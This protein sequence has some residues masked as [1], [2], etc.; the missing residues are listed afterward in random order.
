MPPALLVSLTIFCLVGVAAL[1]LRAASSERRR[2]L[3]RRFGVQSLRM[4]LSQAGARESAERFEAIF[5]GILRWVTQRVPEGS[6]ESTRVQQL[7]RRLMQAGFYNAD[8]IKNFRL[9]RLGLTAGC[10]AIAL[11]VCWL[12]GLD[13]SHTRLYFLV[14]G[15]VGYMA[16]A[17]Y[18]TRRGANRRNRI[19]RE[20][21]DT[22]DL[23]T[24]CVEAGLSMF[25][26]IKTV[27]VESTRRG[28]TIGDELAMVS[29][30]VAIG[31]SLGDAL[32]NL[33]ERTAVEEI[34][35]LAATLI[36]SEQLGAQ[37]APALRASSDALRSRRQLRAEE[38]AQKTA[39][40][41]LLPL[42]LFVLP[43]MIAVIMGPAFIQIYHTIAH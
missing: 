23:L 41:M 40:K 34:R 24:V 4:L 14:G 21:A 42:V 31:S 25:E 11:L 16:P 5:E 12:A 13:G 20:L 26:G 3:E 19:S 33:A 18:L 6:Q 35:P 17:Q 43:A 15:T 32:R 27:A 38:A 36:Q 22:L 39:V 29:A 30:E 9:V 7:S 37:I 2:A 28:Q 1:M 8:R 10:A